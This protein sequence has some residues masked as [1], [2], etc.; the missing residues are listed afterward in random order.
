MEPGRVAERV[1][2]PA[3]R[4]GGSPRLAER[5]DRHPPRVALVLERE[6]RGG[7]ALTPA[8]G[9]VQFFERLDEPRLGRL[10]HDRRLNVE[11][12]QRARAV[13]HGA[14]RSRRLA[15]NAVAGQVPDDRDGAHARAKTNPG[16][17]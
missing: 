13:V 1:R 5:L 2:D 3:S 16:R 14:A 8:N 17:R 7:A 11:R 12:A 4:L 10:R 6:R 15:R 9:N